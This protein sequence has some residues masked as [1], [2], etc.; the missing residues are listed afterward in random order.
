MK[1]SKLN[2]RLSRKDYLEV[3]SVKDIN[4]KVKEPIPT[5]EKESEYNLVLIIKSLNSVINNI[6]KNLISSNNSRQELNYSD[7]ELY[8]KKFHSKPYYKYKIFPLLEI[9]ETIYIK[10]KKEKAF[11]NSA[12]EMNITINEENKMSNR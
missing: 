2:K 3:L 4:K 10:T 1:N 8:L 11:L 9:L 12:K 7:I 6:P 5:K